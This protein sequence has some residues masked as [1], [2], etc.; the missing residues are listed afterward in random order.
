MDTS[1]WV[2]PS[3]TETPQHDSGQPNV[4]QETQ[5]LRRSPRLAE[6]IEK[7]RLDVGIVQ[8]PGNEP[9]RSPRILELKDKRNAD[10]ENAKRCTVLANPIQRGSIEV[11]TLQQEL[12]LACIQTYAEVTGRQVSPRNSSQQR[13]PTEV[14]NAVLNKDTGDLME[15]RQLLQNPK[16]SEVW[17]KSYTKELGRLA[18]GVPGTKGT[19]TIVFIKY[20]DIPLDRQRHVTYCR[21]MVMYRTKKEDPNRTRFTVGG[22]MI[23]FPG[24]VST[25]TVEMLTVKMHLNSVIS[26]PGA[27]Y[28]TFDIKDFYLMTPMERPEFMRMKL[29]DL[30]ED[31]VKLYNLTNIADS[32]GVVYVKIQKGM[33]GLPQAGILANKLL[34]QRL[35][36]HGY[37]Q[38]PT[39]PGLWKHE[40]RPISFTLCVDDFGVKYVGR[41]HA[42][43]LLKVL[44]QHYTCSQDWDGKRYVGMN[45][46]WDY[47]NQKVHVSMLDYVP[48]ALLRFKHKAPRKPQHQSYPHIK[49]TYGATKQ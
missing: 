27:R 44:T 19:D 4:V 26:T 23:F 46:D 16:Y 18:Q 32:N 35:N 24:D 41:E 37:R 36:Q 22:N 2:L 38:S 31:F 28:C 7:L 42:E 14:L 17:G 43:H 5:H 3:R 45:I 49:P 9:R 10:A 1:E 29:S 6:K 20:D 30:P 33:Y 25:P 40:K 39:T 13:F 11:R 48:E 15:M 12:V 34:E 21:T 47:V 8:K